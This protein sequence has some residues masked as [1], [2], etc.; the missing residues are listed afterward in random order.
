MKGII[1]AV[2]VTFVFAV[3]AFAGEFGPPEHQGR[4]RRILFL[5]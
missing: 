5:S 2:L 3:A 1:A 4:W